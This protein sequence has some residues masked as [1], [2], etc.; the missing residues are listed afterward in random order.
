MA[1]YTVLVGKPA[2]DPTVPAASTTVRI[3]R[4]GDQVTMDHQ[5]T[6]VNIEVNS[7][8]TITAVRCG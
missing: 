1:Q 4:P 8:G 3:I 7:T 6:R 2:T 5:P